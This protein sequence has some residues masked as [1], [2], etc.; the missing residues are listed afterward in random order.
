MVVGPPLEALF[1][2][3]VDILGFLVGKLADLIEFLGRVGNAIANS[4]IGAFIRAVSGFV[5]G[6]LQTFG[7]AVGT[8]GSMIPH[9]AAGGTVEPR[10]GGTLALLGEAGE[11]EY[12]IPQSKLGALGGGGSAVHVHLYLDGDEI[13]YRMEPALGSLFALRGTSARL[14]AGA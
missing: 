2:G 7:N 6:A 4:P 9:F 11:R 13:A 12:V 3:V 1:S 8:I 10:A 5:G 14:G